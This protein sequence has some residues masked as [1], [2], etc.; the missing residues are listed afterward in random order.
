[1]DH[2][3]HERHGPGGSAPSF[4]RSRYG[5]GFLAFAAIAMVFLLTEHRAHV[6]GALPYALLLASPFLHV[7]MHRGHGAHG[8][9][10]DDASDDSTATTSPS[11]KSADATHHHHG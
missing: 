5:I 4:W 3:N 7:F 9:G 1:M 6:L 11:E 2:E 8:H 10:R